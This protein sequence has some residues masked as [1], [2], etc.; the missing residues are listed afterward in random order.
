[1]LRRDDP[2]RRPTYRLCGELK[3]LRG[4]VIPIL[5]AR[6]DA[7]TMLAA[8]KVA[9]FLTLPLDEGGQLERRHLHEADLQECK[10]AFLDPPLYGEEGATPLGVV[11]ELVQEPLANLGGL[12]E[13][14][15]DVAMLELALTLVRNLLA[16][17]D[18]RSCGSRAAGGDHLTRMTDDL[19][20]TLFQEDVMDLLLAIAAV[21]V[22]ENRGLLLL[23]IFH[24]ILKGQ[25][26]AAV[27]EAGHRR[28]RTGGKR[29]G[30]TGGN[31]SASALGAGD[32]GSLR[33]TLLAEKERLRLA[34]R[35]VAQTRHSRFGG[36]IYRKD[37]GKFE[38]EVTFNPWK[39]GQ[40]KY[41]RQMLDAGALAETA[42]PK[43]ASV[44]SRAAKVMRATSAAVDRDYDAQGSCDRKVLDKL[45]DWADALF[46]GPYND[47]VA[48]CKRFIAAEGQDVLQ[49]DGRHLMDVTRFFCE[50][51]LLWFEHGLGEVSKASRRAKDEGKDKE[52]VGRARV[53]AH[54]ALPP[55]ARSFG[56]LSATVDE[57]MFKLAS[58]K[59]L[60]SLPAD[61]VKG[62]MA[63][64]VST[65][66]GDLRTATA[67]IGLIKQMLNVLDATCRHGSRDE[68]LVANTLQLKLFHDWSDTGLLPALRVCMRTF[69]RHKH[70]RKLMVDLA[71]AT[72][73]TLRMLETMT[74]KH[75]SVYVLKSKKRRVAASKRGSTGPPTRV[76]AEGDFI[77]EGEGEPELAT[78]TDMHFAARNTLAAVEDLDAASVDAMIEDIFALLGA[79]DA[80]EGDV[81]RVLA[82]ELHQLRARAEDDSAETRALRLEARRH[83]YKLTPETLLEVTNKSVRT[84]VEATAEARGLTVGDKSLKA[85]CKEEVGVFVVRVDEGGEEAGEEGNAAAAGEEVVVDDEPMAS[86]DEAATADEAAADDD[87][88]VVAGKDGATVEEPTGWA[89]MSDVE[90][91]QGGGAAQTE[92]PAQ[93]AA[94]M[95]TD[96][97]PPA[98]EEGSAPAT[99]EEVAPMGGAED[100]A[101]EDSAPT[102]EAPASPVDAPSPPP[103]PAHEASPPDLEL[104]PDYEDVHARLGELPLPPADALP[105]TLA[106]WGNTQ[107][108]GELKLDES[109]ED[110]LELA[111]VN[112]PTA[113]EGF[114]F[115][116]MGLGAFTPSP[117]P[118]TAAPAPVATEAPAGEQAQKVQTPSD[119]PLAP[120]E[121]FAAPAPA[122][123]VAPDASGASQDLRDEPL[124]AAAP[125]S[126]VAEAPSVPAEVVAAEAAPAVPADAPLAAAGEQVQTEG[127]AEATPAEAAEG[128]AGGAKDG[129]ESGRQGMVAVKEEVAMD[130]KKEVAAFGSA[131][132]FANYC[133]LLEDYATNSP[134]L[135]HA[136]A[137]MLHRLAHDCGMES[138][139]FQLSL[140]GLFY[141][142]LSDH[143]LGRKDARPD[144]KELR[145]FAAQVTR[146]YVRKLKGPLGNLLLVDSLFW[147]TPQEVVLI[148]NDYKMTAEVVGKSSKGGKRGKKGLADGD[149]DVD[150]PPGAMADGDL[151]AIMAEIDGGDGDGGGSAT[152]EKR[153]RSRHFTATGD[154]RLKELWEELKD[155][156]HATRRMANALNEAGLHPRA[157]EGE[158][159]STT[160]V[161]ARLLQLGL[162]QKGER[163]GRAAAARR[164]RAER[165][166]DE[167]RAIG[168]SDSEDDADDLLA[169]DEPEDAPPPEA[170][171]PDA[172][173]AAAS[174][175]TLA[176][177]GEQWS[178]GCS[179]ELV[180]TMARGQVEAAREFERD[181]EAEDMEILPVR[182][183]EWKALAHPEAGT[184][185]RALGFA[186]PGAGAYSFWALRWAAGDAAWRGAV[187]EALAAAE[188]AAEEAANQLRDDPELATWLPAKRTREEE[189]E[190]SLG[191]PSNA[192][193]EEGPQV[194]SSQGGKRLRIKGPPVREPVAIEELMDLEDDLEDDLVDDDVEEEAPAKRAP[195]SGGRRRMA[196][197]VD[198]SDDD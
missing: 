123:Q 10:A 49:S 68:T 106:S 153:A 89:M 150:A 184:L 167:I 91:S 103:S 147:K 47:I 22:F 34:S 25:Q 180:L 145:H 45:R 53:E 66:E 131:R 142:I 76:V 179:A 146:H 51:Q 109:P 95:D 164:E 27:F 177:L 127:G 56:A 171:P 173:R 198:D 190:D 141:R 35:G 182:E 44:H 97:Q 96:E 170:S 41:R 9:V 32:G 100:G 58:R 30:D 161:S 48:I 168:A 40:S 2:T 149:D 52:E 42:K 73:R 105:P 160:H 65:K 189:S 90:G 94:P 78:E 188:R 118:R 1:M 85:I 8:L 157:D 13:V 64:F 69:D 7:K 154:A 124:E 19:L 46:Q 162:R 112:F 136:C 92:A 21:P 130:F 126:Q 17:A 101:G 195:F 104:S 24:F 77:V 129:K 79:L 54:R 192:E 172:T 178:G 158:E 176:I 113:D 67:A 191:V 140:L 174:A 39:A 155:Q 55:P 193:E 16:I 3:L 139:L 169:V 33:D 163:T 28:R 181:G 11:V 144:Q 196:A 62:E 59:W 151:D 5:M 138:Y 61:M 165:R 23:E 107:G 185:L 132:T 15:H 70:P 135:N 38:N 122:G 137:Q 81:R 197:L 20:R 86:A 125:S 6:P 74:A 63:A 87:V 186:P 57:A 43:V 187:E 121:A 114:P 99:G 84:A 120:A 110:E 4:H 166:A 18:P 111:N 134:A 80:D 183:R 156:S 133:F 93:D 108:S 148:D 37:K 83:L 119:T 60:E 72:H 71:E 75:G 88:A 50:Y 31:A 82:D 159:Y 12:T 29:S 36:T 102:E 26:A 128:T 152:K 115:L 143:N 175:R 117:E 116:S 194:M 98:A 14:E